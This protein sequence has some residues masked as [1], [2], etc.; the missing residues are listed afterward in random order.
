MIEWHTRP[1]CCIIRHVYQQPAQAMIP[2]EIQLTGPG[3]PLATRPAPADRR[4]L[5]FHDILSA[6]NPLQYLPVVG[7]LYRG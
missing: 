3:P 2:S 7:T 5:S 6:M 1:V 4:G